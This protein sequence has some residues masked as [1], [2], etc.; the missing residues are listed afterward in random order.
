MMLQD[1]KKNY[2][3]AFFLIFLMIIIINLLKSMFINLSKGVC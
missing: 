1:L 2:E 3:Y